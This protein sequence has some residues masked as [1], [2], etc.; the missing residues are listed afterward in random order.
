M[1][2][3]MTPADRAAYAAACRDLATQAV[4]GASKADADVKQETKRTPAKRG[5]R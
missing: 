3:Y 5:R 1:D 4:K 2:P